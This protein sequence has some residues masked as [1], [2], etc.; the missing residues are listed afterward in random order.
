MLCKDLQIEWNLKCQFQNTNMAR[1]LL[2]YKSLRL[3]SISRP[4]HVSGGRWDNNTRCPYE[5]MT[6]TICAQMYNLI[7][8]LNAIFKNQYGLLMIVSS[9]IKGIS[10]QQT[11][12]WVRCHLGFKHSTS[13]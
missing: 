9:V 2:C 1:L 6:Q 12:V 7:A 13:I 3:P 10:N 8:I 5:L 11:K 4:R